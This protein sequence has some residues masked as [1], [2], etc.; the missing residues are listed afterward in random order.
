MFV[1]IDNRSLKSEHKRVG[2]CNP[3]K[4][5]KEKRADIKSW[6]NVVSRHG[7]CVSNGQLLGLIVTLS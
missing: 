6:Y 1:E 5:I 3:K 4:N 7:K 2:Q